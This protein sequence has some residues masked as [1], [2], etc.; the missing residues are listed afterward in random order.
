MKCLKSGFLNTSVILTLLVAHQ[1]WRVKELLS[2]GVDQLIIT[3]SGISGWFVIE[4][5]KHLILLNMFMVKS[6]KIGLC[7]AC[8]KENG[9]APP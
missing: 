6:R 9:K 7:G 3:T 4:T 1:P 5:V 8:A 2:C